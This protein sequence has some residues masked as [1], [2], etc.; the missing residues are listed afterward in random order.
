MREGPYGAR[1]IKIQTFFAF[2]NKWGGYYLLS[3][4]KPPFKGQKSRI[5]YDDYD[6]QLQ[7]DL[8]T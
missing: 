5:Y 7:Q 8:N 2:S 3:S 4:P 1:K 6:L